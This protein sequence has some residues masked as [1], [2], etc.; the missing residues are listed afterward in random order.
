MKSIIAKGLLII[1]LISMITNECYGCII[2]LD[3]EF[4]YDSY[5][6]PINTIGYIRADVNEGG[7]LI[8]LSPNIR[9]DWSETSGIS[10]SEGPYLG[11]NDFAS[12]FIYSDTIG[13]YNYVTAGGENESGGTDSDTVIIHFYD[14]IM[15]IV[16]VGD[17]G[18]IA[19]NNDDDN[20]NGV[21]DCDESA[22]EN[23]DDLIAIHLTT[24]PLK[25]Y[26][27]VTLEIP[28]GSECLRIWSSPEMT[29]R[30]IPEGESS[31]SWPASHLPS[32]LYVDATYS[33]SGGNVINFSFDP[34][35]FR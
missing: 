26:G 20:N 10:Y 32:T 6:I 35:W 15:N 19:V 17:E 24:D 29:N 13:Y 12:A 18:Y 21:P 28:D 25:L 23:E 16:G 9:W 3:I 22:V 1:I 30:V 2:P 14:L 8:E 11:Y 34:R 27:L 31:H 5:S 33:S 4:G 7:P